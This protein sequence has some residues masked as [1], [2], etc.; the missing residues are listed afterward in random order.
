MKNYSIV[1]RFKINQLYNRR[2]RFGYKMNS[3][4]FC[5]LQ[6]HGKLMNYW[7]FK[8][9]FGLHCKILKVGNSLFGSFGLG[10]MHSTKNC[11][12][13]IIDKMMQEND[14]YI[15]DSNKHLMTGHKGNSEFCF[16]ETLNIEVEGKLTVP[17]VASH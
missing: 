17:F 7:K 15:G 6:I 2:S 4:R 10:F 14:N 8:N 9:L 1:G 11:N 16:L 5:Q 13:W 12:M 3:S